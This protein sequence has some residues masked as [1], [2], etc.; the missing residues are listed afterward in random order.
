[1]YYY[2]ASLATLSQDDLYSILWFGGIAGG[3]LFVLMPLAISMKKIGEL[4]NHRGDNVVGA[5]SGTLL[6]IFTISIFWLFA[7]VFL[8]TAYMYG[9]AGSYGLNIAEATEW[10]LHTDW[11]AN[12]ENLMD[13]IDSIKPYGDEA[14]A[15]AENTIGMIYMVKLL[16]VLALFGYA[17]LLTVSVTFKVNKITKENKVNSFEYSAALGSGAM[18]SV[19]ILVGTIYF[20]NAAIDETFFISDK[21]KSTSLSSNSASIHTMYLDALNEAA[22]NEALSTTDR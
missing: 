19:V 18:L 8:Y 16:W 17:V 7:M 10:F 11:L 3:I 9:T 12:T 13:S 15:V 1:M 14:I 6:K 22:I 2:H 21:I 5:I 20:I 4:N